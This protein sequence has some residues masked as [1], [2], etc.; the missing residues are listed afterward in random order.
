MFNLTFNFLTRHYPYS[1]L[2]LISYSYSLCLQT[3]SGTPN[4]KKKL[5][6]WT[7]DSKSK[8]DDPRSTRI[9]KKMILFVLFDYFYK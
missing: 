2:F 9:N 7:V 4:K 6:R 1:H 5:S 8:V 3:S